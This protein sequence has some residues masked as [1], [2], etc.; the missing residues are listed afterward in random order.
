MA[1][2][3]LRQWLRTRD[4]T[5]TLDLTQL[6]VTKSLVRAIPVEDCAESPVATV[7]R[8]S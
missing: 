8:R 6:S 3:R 1:A 2:L 4:R 5:R 7:V